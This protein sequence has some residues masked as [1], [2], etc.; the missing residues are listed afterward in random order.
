MVAN[1]FPYSDR[2]APPSEALLSGRLQL[3]TLTR[4]DAEAM[5]RMGIVPEDASTELLN[6]WIVLKD[7]SARDQDP[8]MIGQ[9]HRK[10]V[11]RLSALRKTIDNASRHVESQ[12]P[13][14][15]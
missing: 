14:V 5:V 11:E 10:C 12:Q 15:C 9:D 3:I 1:T 8:T 4:K 6:G 7:R 2:F 13:L